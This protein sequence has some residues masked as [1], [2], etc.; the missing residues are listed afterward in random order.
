MAKVQESAGFGLFTHLY[1]KKRARDGLRE[2]TAQ[3]F[4]EKSIAHWKTL[5]AEQRK[6]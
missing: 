5:T 2:I 1:E 4:E 6:R 3:Q